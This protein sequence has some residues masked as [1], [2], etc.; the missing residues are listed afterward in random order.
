MTVNDLLDWIEGL[1]E[2]QKELPIL[3][4]VHG[5]EPLIVPKVYADAV[6]LVWK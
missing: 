5:I 4:D 3:L 2:E 6:Y 1:T